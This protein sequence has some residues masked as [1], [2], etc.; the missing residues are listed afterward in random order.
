M[1]WACLTPGNKGENTPFGSC[2]VPSVPRRDSLFSFHGM[3]FCTLTLCAAQERDTTH[4]TH[5]LRDIPM[6]MRTLGSPLWVFFPARHTGD[7]G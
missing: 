3:G 6:S 7:L 5:N 2:G 1:L 4:A